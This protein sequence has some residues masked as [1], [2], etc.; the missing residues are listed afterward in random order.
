MLKKLCFTL[1][2]AVG[3]FAQTNSFALGHQAGSVSLSPGIAQ[4]K[5]ASGLQTKNK[6]LGTFS[7]GYDVTDNLSAVTQVGLLRSSRRD[8]ANRRV[9]L[10][11]VNF[12][13]EYRF[14]HQQ[15]LQPFIFAGVG[16]INLKPNGAISSD[17]PQGDLARTQATI[18]GG[19]GA[20]YFF[21]DRVA[22]RGDVRD[23]YI[24]NQS[25]NNVLAEASLVFTFHHVS[26]PDLSDYLK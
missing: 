25:R 9:T 18:N 10:S 26:A 8:L 16:I 23:L 4:I 7:V 22:L 17:N 13:G 3:L 24:M 19:V 1:I 12:D 20:E 14:T 21:N 5:L 11:M 6:L 15:A 2:G